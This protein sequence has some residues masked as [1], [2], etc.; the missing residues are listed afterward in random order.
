MVARNRGRSARHPFVGES[1]KAIE[2]YRK[3]QP[4]IGLAV[5]RTRQSPRFLSRMEGLECTASRN[6]VPGVGI[7]TAIPILRHGQS[8]LIPKQH[9]PKL[10]FQVRIGRF[11]NG[12]S[13]SNWSSRGRSPP[14][15]ILTNVHFSFDES[16]LCHVALTRRAPR[17]ESSESTSQ[18]MRNDGSL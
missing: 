1:A 3:C 16:S 5:T 11:N 12:R 13:G 4:A 17:S 18:A 15:R 10:H 6:I 9:F 8:W 7:L 14:W 2:L